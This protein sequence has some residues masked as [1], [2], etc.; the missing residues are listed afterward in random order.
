[1][2]IITERLQLQWQ[3]KT[4]TTYFI[5]EYIA[6]VGRCNHLLHYHHLLQYYNLRCNCMVQEVSIHNLGSFRMLYGGL[7]SFSGRWLPASRRTWRWRWR[8]LIR[9]FAKECGLCWK[10]QL[11]RPTGAEKL[12]WKDSFASGRTSW[13]SWTWPTTKSHQ[14][15]PSPH[16]C[17]SCW[18][19]NSLPAVKWRCA[20]NS[21]QRN[22]YA[23]EVDQ[24]TNNWQIRLTMLRCF[25]FSHMLK[26]NNYKSSKP[27]LLVL[28]RYIISNVHHLW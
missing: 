2:G 9:K 24:L 22:G 8:W 13:W 12:V 17:D 11:I 4:Y 16:R 23:P 14:Q 10:L 25:L 5:F 26:W 19:E 15:T 27:V 20:T 21:S 18:L 7:E 1:M 28:L 6:A 3:P